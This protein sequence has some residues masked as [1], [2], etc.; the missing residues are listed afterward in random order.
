MIEIKNE[1]LKNA[2]QN[3]LGIIKDS[4]EVEELNSVYDIIIDPVGFDNNYV[5]ID[6]DEVLY[7]KN[8]KSISIFN[9]Y[10]N[11]TTLHKLNEFKYLQSIEFYNCDFEN[12][13][14]LATLK[15]NKLK[16]NNCNIGDIKFI[17]NIS[18]LREL[19]L[20]NLDDIDL[21]DIVILDNLKFLS[22]QNTKVMNSNRL[23][24]CK[25]IEFL[26]IDNT[27]IVNLMF[28]SKLKVLKKVVISR[29]QGL[30]NRNQIEYLLNN[31]LN[32]VDELNQDIGDYNE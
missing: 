15:I 29:V 3:S 13:L 26:R 12:I 28:L 25:D 32:I 20:E 22:L 23:V 5:P 27:G 8:L 17:N 2:I 11:M 10:F 31:G 9:F 4:F 6:F 24:V 1:K 30:V 16:F 19:S 7:L 21:N 14:P 18:T